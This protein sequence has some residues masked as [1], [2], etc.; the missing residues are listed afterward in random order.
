MKQ[1]TF[2]EGVIV[3]VAASVF[4]SAGALVLAPLFGRGDMAYMLICAISFAYLLYLLARSRERVGR[5]TIVVLWLAITGIAGFSGLPLV[6]LGV[7]QLGFIWLIRSMYF[8]ASVLSALLD[9]GLTLLSVI[10][11]F[12]AATHTGSVFLSIWTFFLLQ[13]LFVVIPRQMRSTHN[14]NTL[15]LQQ[16][17]PFLH[18]YRSAEAAIRKLTTVR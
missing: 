1:P 6:F 4:G 14:K 5:I 15:P 2:F 3:A 17:D 11:A 8:Y 12:W 16:E 13:A 7:M 9:L 10:T 18:A